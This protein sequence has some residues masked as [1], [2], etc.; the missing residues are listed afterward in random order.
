MKLSLE[1][2]KQLQSALIDAFPTT[3]QLEQ[4]LNHQL[5]KNLGAIAGEGSLQDIVFK[6]IQTAN[7]QGWIEDLICEACNY[8]SGNSQLGSIFQKLIIKNSSTL[9]NTIEESLKEHEYFELEELGSG[10]TGVTYR[11]RRGNDQKLIVLKTIKNDLLYRII[12]SANQEL[13]ELDNAITNFTKEAEILSN[14]KHRHIVSYYD[15]LTIEYKFLINNPDK[16]PNDKPYLLR[17]LNLLFLLMEYIEGETLEEVLSR[18]DSPLEN[19]EALGY[20]QQIG[21]ALTFVHNKDVLHRDI[22]PQN[23]MVRKTTNDAVLIDFGIAREFNS[24]VT[25]THTV[26]FTQGYASPEQLE[27]R[28]KRGNYTDVYGLAATFFYLLTKEH[29]THAML[30]KSDSSSFVEPKKINSNISDRVNEAILWG[31]ELEPSK[32]PR[33]VQQW[34]AKLEYENNLRLYEQELYQALEAGYP[35]DDSVRNGLKKLQQSLGV[36]DE[37]VV[38]IEQRLPAPKQAEYERQQEAI[39]R[40]QE[41]VRLENQKRLAEL[42]EQE[43]RKS[44]P[45]ISNSDDDLSSECNVDYTRLRDLLK[46]GNWKD[47]D[48]ETYLVMLKVVGRESGDWI[49]DEELLNFPCTDLRTIDRLWVKYSNG[50]FGFSVQ[51]K[52]YLEVG[53][54]PDGKYYEEAWKK[55]G[56]RI[57][58]R[59]KE[60][61]LSY[62]D[63]TFD[64]IAPLGHLPRMGKE[65]IPI[66]G[67]RENSKYATW[68]ERE[69]RKA[70][71]D[72]FT[73]PLRFF[74]R[75]HATPSSTLSLASRLVK[76]NL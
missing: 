10:A 54:K 57:G 76:C 28:A 74:S 11:V 51:K 75:D 24:K 68:R 3:V 12:K 9:Y 36:R 47:A 42:K 39:K 52:I 64:T 22:K 35:L 26:A 38:P 21:E 50:R 17:Q 32:R 70:F 56:D 60:S 13:K 19:K 67:E 25:Q 69:R 4:M 66:S 65:K 29:P 41:Q 49:R 73:P 2:R 43:Q 48:Y 33:T 23:I 16:K 20:I 72:F 55:F 7:A 37:D 59:V 61:W 53:G 14:F 46:A 15:H 45:P 34:L 40:E 8:N 18:R 30:R 6:L 31:M 63:V 5:D 27:P 71:G 44:S 62:T 1:L 58:W